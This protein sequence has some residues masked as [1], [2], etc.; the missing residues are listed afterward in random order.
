MLKLTRRLTVASFAAATALAA[1]IVPAAAAPAAPAALP[2]VKV[3]KGPKWSPT[4]VTA[5]PKAFTTCTKAAADV[6]LANTTTKSQTVTYKGK[7]FGT[8]APKSKAWLCEDAAAGFKFV[9]GLKGS[10]SKL[11]VTMS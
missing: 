6:T 4:A 9:Y 3:Q 11:T 7:A 1:T 5:A 10:K 2:A 8:I